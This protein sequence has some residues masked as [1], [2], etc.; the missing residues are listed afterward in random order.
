MFPSSAPR[1]AFRPHCRI[2]TVNPLNILAPGA[3]PPLDATGESQTLHLLVVH[4][5][6]V[7]GQP[8]GGPASTASGRPFGGLETTYQR[9]CR[10]GVIWGAQTAVEDDLAHPGR[11]EECV[12]CGKGEREALRGEVYGAADGAALDDTA[13]SRLIRYPKDSNGCT[14]G[15]TRARLRARCQG[16]AAQQSSETHL[17][18]VPSQINQ[19]KIPLLNW[20]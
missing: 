2:I 17:K 19:G 4:A 13:R 15:S 6:D 18:I 12:N 7:I 8:A 1:A 5:G 3:R 16:A 10:G 9:E 20:S 14:R 11:L